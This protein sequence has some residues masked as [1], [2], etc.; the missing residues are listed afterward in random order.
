MGAVYRA[1][2]PEMGRDV[3]LKMVHPARRPKPRELARFRAE[4]EAIARLQHPNIVQVFEVGEDRGSPY[5]AL[6]LV[7]KGTLQQKLQA[8]E[9]L[10]QL[11]H[12]TVTL[13]IQDK[14]IH[15]RTD[16]PLSPI[17]NAYSKKIQILQLSPRLCLSHRMTSGYRK[18]LYS[19][20]LQSTRVC[21]EALSSYHAVMNKKVSSLQDTCNQ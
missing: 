6:E 15:L 7:E 12:E 18:I 2:D 17:F 21:L 13:T 16:T 4:A 19:P 5:L 20:F 9:L 10:M 3:A 14:E 1:H 11:T 8:A